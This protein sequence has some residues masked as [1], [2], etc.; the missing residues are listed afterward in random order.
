MKS[1]EASLLPQIY[2]P[3]CISRHKNTVMIN[4]ANE[5]L[6]SQFTP[7]SFMVGTFANNPCMKPDRQK[8][9]PW[10]EKVIGD[11]GR[12]AQSRTVRK[13]GAAEV[14]CT[15]LHFKETMLDG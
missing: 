1:K 12:K 10:K 7:F 13:D 15:R 8:M 5:E 2:I 11:A 14:C 4:K 9:W 6:N 3:P